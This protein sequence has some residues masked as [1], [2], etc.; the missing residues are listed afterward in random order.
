MPTVVTTANAVLHDEAEFERCTPV[1][2]VTMKQAQL[3]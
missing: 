2:A 3:T 1:T